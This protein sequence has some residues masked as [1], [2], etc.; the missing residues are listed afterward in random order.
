MADRFQEV[1]RIP[2]NLFIEGSPVLIETGVILKDTATDK[3]LS[4]VKIKNLER[5]KII[6]CK[7]AIRAFGPDGTELEGIPEYLYLDVNAETG[8]NFGAKT[9]IHLPNNNSRK[10]S[11]SVTQVVLDDETVWNHEPCEWMQ[12][13]EQQYI[14]DYF[15]DSEFK[16]QYSLEVG[17]ECAFVPVIRNGLFQCTCGTTNLAAAADCYHC[18]R[19]YEDLAAKLDTEFLAAQI[20]IRKAEE[21]AA[22]EAEE[23]RRIAEA[24]AEEE[25]RIAEARAAE[26][27]RQAEEE[28]KRKI[29]KKLKIIIPIT[30]AIAL[31]AILIPTVIKPAIENS[32]A[33]NAATKLLEE[34]SYDEAKTAF[35]ALGDYK[36][37]SDMA[38]ESQYRKADSLAAEKKY[39]DAIK[40]WTS[41]GKYTDSPSRVKEAE[42]EWKDDDYQDAVALME[43]GEYTNASKAFETL[44]NYKDSSDLSKKCLELEKEEI[45]QAAAAD[46]SGS[47]FED[48]LKKYKELGNYKDSGDLYK[49]TAYE[50]ACF[51]ADSGDYSKALEY[52]D[53]LKGYEDADNRKTDALY[54]IACQSLNDHK[55]SLAITQFE[56]CKDY[57]DASSKVLDAKYG[58][59]S[60][61][62]DNSNSTTYDYLQDLIS[63]DYSGAQSIYDELYTWSVENL[64]VN[65]DV[66]DLT[67]DYSS[68]SKYNAIYFHLKL[69]GGPPGASTNIT[70]IATPPSGET[71][72]TVLGNY[73]DGSIG[74]AY[75]Y[76]HIPAYGASGTLTVDYYDS[77][78]NHIGTCS[79]YITD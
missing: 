20:E 45:Y 8:Q 9:P 71:I 21:K 23:E 25:R 72:Q 78:D 50:Y 22:S 79:V 1:Y 17:P 24:K 60:E 40:L 49:S 10:M 15:S 61:N 28:K 7:A 12:V 42:A 11:V 6:A 58:Y 54:N 32:S 16:K 30:V 75:F 67:T 66:N 59:I 62:K 52:F 55:Y 19:K 29:R 44:G 64:A 13:P 57:M 73:S 56:K 2:P 48:A 46:V 70:A 68:I 69:V 47:N 65:T 33:Y 26:E 41:L 76:Y 5:R 43:S 39:E 3:I 14:I 63:A 77:S 31:L 51:L 36:D 4:L 38:L 53:K 35:E 37:S 34:G 74:S 18:H 27:K